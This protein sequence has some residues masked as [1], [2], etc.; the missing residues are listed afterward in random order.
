MKLVLISIIILISP[1]VFS[2]INSRISL[3]Q[4]LDSIDR[5]SPLIKSEIEKINLSRAQV[6]IAKSSF[7]L[8][9]QLSSGEQ[10]NG[11]PENR[12]NESKIQT[13]IFGTGIL[14][15]L[16]WDEFDGTVP[17]YRQSELTGSEGRLKASLQI[18]L[19]RNLLTDPNRTNLEINKLTLNSTEQS[20][21]FAKMQIYIK[22]ALSY[23]NWLASIEKR[24][25][26][27]DLLQLALQ[28]REFINKK[29]KLGDS[30]KIDLIEIERII[31]EREN[32][33]LKS[34]Q[35]EFKASQDLSLFLRDTEGQVKVP[36]ASQA[37]N[38][39]QET[40]SFNVV[41]THSWNFSEFPILKSMELLIQAQKAELK[42]FKQER[43]P[44]LN[45]VLENSE[46]YGDL[47]INRQSSTES[48]VGF[49][50]TFPILN[51]EAKGK[52]S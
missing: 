15:T 1:K 30:P 41:D 35:N 37:K 38:L 2:E 3:E 11:Y 45:L 18:P 26:S 50:L 48:F 16:A 6:E 7:D 52:Y 43:L 19:L 42:L 20:F 9:W 39:L 32:N 17:V 8:N 21:R 51:L 47:P 13:Q 24:K 28:R 23:Y 49:T 4:V 36:Q 14:A 10:K 5:H 12:K 29:V 40:Q 44:K 25:I 31:F 33:L 46:Y 27:E 34:S 22:A